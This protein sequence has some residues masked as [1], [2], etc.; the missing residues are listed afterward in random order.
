MREEWRSAAIIGCCGDKSGRN[1]HVTNRLS[2]AC[3]EM[4]QKGRNWERM[5]GKTILGLRISMISERKGRFNG[6]P[7]I[8]PQARRSRWSASFLDR[9]W[10]GRYN[11]KGICCTSVVLFVEGSERDEAHL[12]A[13]S[14]ASQEAAW[15]SQPYVVQG[16]PAGDQEE[17]VA[18]KKAPDSIR[19]RTRPFL[20]PRS[21]GTR[22]LGN[23]C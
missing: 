11:R 7:G 17:A 10:A 6:H 18:G 13:Q 19:P 3:P 2:P 1:K 20:S 21:G 4:S 23:G 8:Y 14:S 12:S 5:G 22:C 15:L 16:R 9:I